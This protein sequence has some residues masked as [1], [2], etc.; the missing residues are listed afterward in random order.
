MGLKENLANEPVRRLNL[1]PA[2]IVPPEAK[3]REGILAM[4]NAH[5]GCVIIAGEDHK[6]VGMFT[7]GIL[8]QLLAEN[9]A[10][11]DEPIGDRAA[12]TFPWVALDDSIQTVL[13]AMQANNTR[14]ICVVDSEGRV[15]ALT[16]QKGLMEYVA[17][18]FPRQ[19]M[20][21]RVGTPYAR[22]REGA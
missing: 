4:R 11:I 6:P 1:R 22:Q 14:F 16:G 9:P 20:V 5:L 7:E 3:I 15:C 13:D 19:V 8:R 10:V 12:R 17:E 21:Q 2:V 18:H